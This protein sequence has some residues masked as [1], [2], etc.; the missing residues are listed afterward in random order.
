MIDRRRA[1]FSFAVLAVAATALSSC[2][3]GDARSLVRDDSDVRIVRFTI[4][5]APSGPANRTLGEALAREYQQQATGHRLELLESDGGAVD[6]LDAIQRGTTD[7]GVSLADVTYLAY[8][9]RLSG[10]PQPYD[11]V[12]G[13]TVLDVAPIHVLARPGSGIRQLRDLPGHIVALGPPGSET[14][15]AAG[16]VLQAFGVDPATVHAVHPRFDEAAASLKQGAVD[17]MFFTASAPAALVQSAIDDGARLLPLQG[18]AVV[19]L[20]QRYPFLRFARI[21]GGIYTSHDEAVRTIGVEKVVLCR[22]GL[23]DDLVY[24]LASHLFELLP[25][26]AE[27][28]GREWYSALGHAPATPVPLHAGAASFF[29]ERELF[30]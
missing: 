7:C 17:A 8:A 11:D 2:V 25:R 13:V 26:V 30:P 21:H 4:G 22:R 18:D 10:R 3:P 27:S 5:L 24:E 28:A 14:R 6:T 19:G 16:L 15:V 9:G 29:R 12:R 1:T 20:L 23:A